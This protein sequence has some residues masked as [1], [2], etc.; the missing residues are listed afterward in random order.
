MALPYETVEMICLHAASAPLHEGNVA[1]VATRT[2]RRMDTQPMYAVVTTVQVDNPD[3]AR[4]LLPEAREALVSRAPGIVCGYWLEPVAGI[5]MSI[6]VFE[7]KGHAE[8]AAKYPVPPMP[9]VV[10][11]ELTI[12]QVVAH[13]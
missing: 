4:R 9:G 2:L 10:V 1:R 8:E 12:R 3:E 11:L 5:G 7:S 13:V 6:L